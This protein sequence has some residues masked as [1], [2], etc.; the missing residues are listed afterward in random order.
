MAKRGPKGP[1][2]YTDE[3]LDEL[4]KDMIKWFKKEG[5]FWIGEFAAENDMLREQLWELAHRRE[6]KHEEFSNAYMRARELQETKLV[7][8][9]IQKRNFDSRFVKFVL[10]NNHDWK[11]KSERTHKVDKWD[12]LLIDI[13][14]NAKHSIK[15]ENADPEIRDP[16]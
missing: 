8:M 9:G 2:K 14:E 12:R 15:P 13:R 11:E 4:A 3:V 10:Q 1:S 7:R 6:P 5:N 16:E